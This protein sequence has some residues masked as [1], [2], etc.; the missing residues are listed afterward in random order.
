MVTHINHF[1]SLNHTMCKRQR[2][3]IFFTMVNSPDL[4]VYDGSNWLD[5]IGVITIREN[6]YFEREPIQRKFDLVMY[7][8]SAGQTSLLQVQ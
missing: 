1:N 5:I 3:Q 6:K 2:S 8:I 4:S 7:F